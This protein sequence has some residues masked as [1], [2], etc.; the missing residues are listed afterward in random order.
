MGGVGVWDAN[1]TF[2]WVNSCPAS[3]SG[4]MSW[5]DRL[6]QGRLR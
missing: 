6:F 2:I 5:G 4:E 1:P 3:L